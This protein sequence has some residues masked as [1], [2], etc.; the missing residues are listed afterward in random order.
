MPL[1][2]PFI[3]AATVLYE[4]TMRRNQIAVPFIPARGTTLPARLVHALANVVAPSIS[5]VLRQGQM[6][7]C[8]TGVWDGEPPVTFAYQWRRCDAG[9]GACVDIVG[10]TASV[11]IVQASDIGGTLRCVVTA[12]Y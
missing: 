6:V 7:E 10:A 11:Y 12:S 8:S 3:D 5:G 2:A 1:S 4:P 9:G